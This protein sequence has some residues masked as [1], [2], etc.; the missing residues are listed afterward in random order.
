MWKTK[1][2]LS[3]DSTLEQASLCT[4]ILRDLLRKLKFLDKLVYVTRI[5]LSNIPNIL[6]IIQFYPPYKLVITAWFV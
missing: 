1:R 5:R 6:V 2:G 3:I 4:K